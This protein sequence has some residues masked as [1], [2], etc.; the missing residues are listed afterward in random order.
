MEAICWVLLSFVRRQ[1]QWQ[2][3]ILQYLSMTGMANVDDAQLYATLSPGSR[4]NHC[5]HW[6][7]IHPL[8]LEQT[9]SV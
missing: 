7:F 8:W 3:S 6:P 1:R 2:L 5:Q 9:R 4:D